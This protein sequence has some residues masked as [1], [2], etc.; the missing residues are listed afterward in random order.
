MNKK[1]ILDI[2][3]LTVSFIQYEQ[4][5]SNK[6]E[7]PV[8]SDLNVTVREGE[9]VAVVGSSGSG[10]SLLAHTVLGLL[11]QNSFAQGELYFEGE[12]LDKNKI[13]KLRGHEI[14]LVPQS[15]KYLNPL[16]KIGKQL[17]NG[18]KDKKVLAEMRRLEKRYGFS[19][20]IEKLYPFELSGGMARRVLLMT[21]LLNHPRLIIADEP[22]PGLE[23]SL[24]KKA[25][26]DFRSFADEGNGVLLI[27]HDL[28]LALEVA[29][30]IVVFY[31]GMTVEEAFAEDFQAE[32]NLRHPYTRALY[33]A[34]PEH[35]FQ[36]AAGRQPY[37]KE[38]PKGCPFSP[39]CPYYADKCSGKISVQ[40]IRGGKVRCV[41]YSG[42]EAEFDEA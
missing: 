20:D 28:E 9:L 33:R 35:G 42:E 38:M 2:R 1:E 25:M 29:D 12:L 31:A 37:V 40:K 22:T 23:L 17:T 36:A 10:K 8:I 5:S 19:Q 14:S 15:V 6:I 4:Q 3:N 34:M 41:R 7:L 27:T 39:R 24:A 16:M 13:E 21:A 32:K 18:K 26:E 11:P 30:R